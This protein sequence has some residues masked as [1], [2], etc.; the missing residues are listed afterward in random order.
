MGVAIF[1]FEKLL[2]KESVQGKACR[3]ALGYT[4]LLARYTTITRKLYF[5]IRC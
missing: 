5:E 1:G 3:S 4:H 2:L